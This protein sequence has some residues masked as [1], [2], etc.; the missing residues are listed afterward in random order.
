M[1]ALLIILAAP[2]AHAESSNS[3][4]FAKRLLKVSG[5]PEQFESKAEQQTRA[6]IRTYLSIVNMSVDVRLP[7][8]I[9][10]RIADCYRVAYAWENFEDGIAEIVSQEMNDNEMLLLIDFYQDLGL[11][12]SEI[13]T[14]KATLAKVP[15]IQEFS[16]NFIFSESVGCV[17]QDAKIINQYLSEVGSP[18]YISSA[19]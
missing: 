11:P 14:F 13:D 4:R 9:T 2:L 1:M 16:A 15:E 18:L 8:H 19:P 17:Q 12:P 7:A 5:T 3:I 6:I 10:S